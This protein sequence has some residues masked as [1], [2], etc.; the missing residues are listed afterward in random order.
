MAFEIIKKIFEKLKNA[1]LEK[2]LREI[3]DKME[4][5]EKVIGLLQ[6]IIGKRLEDRRNGKG[7]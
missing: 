2:C 6:K 7:T 5:Q 1:T 3:L 4:S